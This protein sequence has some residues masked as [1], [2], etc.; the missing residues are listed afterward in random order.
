M[1]LMDLLKG[2]KTPKRRCASCKAKDVE[3][4]ISKK[5]DAEMH[6]FCCKE[7][8]RQFRIDR[9]RA[10]KKPQSAGSSLPW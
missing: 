4:P 9:K 2:N 10:A 5:F 6:L 7:C 8:E 3:L 1:G